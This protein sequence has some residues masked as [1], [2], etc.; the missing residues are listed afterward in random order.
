MLLSNVALFV[1]VTRTRILDETGEHNLD[2]VNEKWRW[3]RPVLLQTARVMRASRPATP[4]SNGR[5]ERQF[6]C[7]VGL[8]LR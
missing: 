5:G 8:G 2:S 1:N 4:T 3:L 6:V 7:T